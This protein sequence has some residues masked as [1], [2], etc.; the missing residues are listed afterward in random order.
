VE[1]RDAASSLDAGKL[2]EPVLLLTNVTRALDGQLIAGSEF[3]P[4]ITREMGQPL[5]E[6]PTVFNFF[7]P[8]NRIGDTGLY[9][10]EF[11]I[12]TPVTAT[13]RS[14]WMFRLLNQNF[15]REVTVNTDPYVALAPDPTQLVNY[16]DSAFFYR[17]MSSELRTKI[18]DTISRQSDD[19][20]RR[21]MSA[22]WLSVASG[23]YQVQH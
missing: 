23:E 19:R 4:V 10:P 14:N 1:A 22:L 16:V 6:S 18:I 3:K 11:Q 8:L 2:K 17:R 5:L 21:A 7:S 9:G 15:W 20:G 13:A 12:L